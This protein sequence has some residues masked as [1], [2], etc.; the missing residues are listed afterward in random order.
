MSGHVLGCMFIIS[1]LHYWGLQKG[2]RMMNEGILGRVISKLDVD[3]WSSWKISGT[4]KDEW[5]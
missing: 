1:I 5:R 3:S 2:G 4:T